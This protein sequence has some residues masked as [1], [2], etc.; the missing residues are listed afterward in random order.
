MFFGMRALSDLDE[1]NYYALAYE[2]IA[3]ILLLWMLI[4]VFSLFCFH[5]FL[6]LTNR[7]TY[8]VIKKRKIKQFI[9]EDMNIQDEP[10]KREEFF[11]NCILRLGIFHCA[12]LEPEWIY[13][14]RGVANVSPN[15]P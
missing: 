3:F 1:M 14:P 8:E 6:A 7:T 9:E 10:E 11:R 5:S 2:A 13:S 12:K 4:A 15:S